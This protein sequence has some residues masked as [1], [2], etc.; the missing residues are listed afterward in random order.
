[1]VVLTKFLVYFVAEII[2]C[3]ICHGASEALANI[4]EDDQN[5]LMVNHVIDKTCNMLPGKYFARVSDRVESVI[6]ELFI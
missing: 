5:S 3:A 1:M 2:E 6:F 4:Y